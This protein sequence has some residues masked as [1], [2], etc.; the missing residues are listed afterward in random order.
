M[1]ASF[2]DLGFIQSQFSALE[3]ALRDNRIIT[4]FG[5]QSPFSSRFL[6]STTHEVD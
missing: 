2:D 1:F 5:A 4:R 3:R 6:H